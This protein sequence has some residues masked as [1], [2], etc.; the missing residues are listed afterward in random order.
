[1]KNYWSK[2]FSKSDLLHLFEIVNGCHDCNS[3]C[4]FN[5]L[6]CKL[7]NIVGFDAAICTCAELSC[8]PASFNKVMQP[9]NHHFPKP[10]MDHMDMW[11]LN[12]CYKIDIPLQVL[13]SHLNLPETF[14]TNRRFDDG[15]LKI[16]LPQSNSRRLSDGWIYGSYEKVCNRWI[17]CI[18][19]FQSHLEEP[20]SS[21]A[22]EL[23]MPQLLFAF[24]GLRHLCSA[25]PFHLTKR[26][27]E[28]LN[29]IKVGKTTW[30]ISQILAISESCVNFHIDNLK[31]KLNSVNRG[32]ALAVAVANGL[33]K[34]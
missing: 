1:M 7:K 10:L 15:R 30:E 27:Y 31:R 34:I 12:R 29:W 32:Q 20:R 5:G 24:R 17:L 3:F 19:A 14:N 28:I 11:R 8:L 16:V 23:V 25:Q 2:Y 4:V 18:F 21:I 9:V 22:I 33:I 6:L 13:L 26:E